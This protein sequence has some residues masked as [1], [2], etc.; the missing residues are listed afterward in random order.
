[1]HRR[2]EARSIGVHHSRRE[3]FART[4]NLT[5][6]AALLTPALGRGQPSNA[7][8]MAICLTPGSIGVSANQMEAIA[9]AERHGFEAVEPFGGYLASLTEQQIREI[10]AGLKAKRLVWGAAGLPVEFRQ[11]EGKF[12]EGLK[13]LPRIAAAL[14]K[15]GASRV[16]TWLSPGHNSLTYLQNFRQHAH[17][18]REAAR[19]LKDHGHRLGLEYVGTQTS[20][21]NRKYPFIHTMAET[22]DLIAEIGTGNVGLVLDSWHWWQAGD[23]VE[24]ILSLKNEEIVSVDLNDAPANVPKEQQMDGQRELP[25]ATGVIDVAAFLKAL[26]RVGYDGPVR[27]E[28]FNRALSDLDNEAACA[29]TIKAMRKAFELLR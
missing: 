17:R 22:K 29:A 18:L 23:T 1:M 3:F 12:N 8:K 21:K 25:C 20:W 15:A 19:V 26:E 28:P 16:G 5:V 2:E 14:A 7:K 24:D 11:D 27:A 4:L 13:T 6:G 10:V 9:L